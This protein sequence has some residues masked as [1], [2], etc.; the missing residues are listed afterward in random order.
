MNVV[1]NVWLLTMPQG[2][3]QVEAVLPWVAPLQ[4]AATVAMKPLRPLHEHVLIEIS[5][6]G[7]RGIMLSG[8]GCMMKRRTMM[9]A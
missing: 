3:A 1:K 8:L 7:S 5:F 2:E 4:K 9:S 6:L